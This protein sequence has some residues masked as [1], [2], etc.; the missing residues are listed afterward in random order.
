MGKPGKG[1]VPRVHSLQTE[2]LLMI[3]AVMVNA[4]FGM[5]EGGQT[6]FCYVAHG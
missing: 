2:M 4:D 1:C 6:P 5:C 3:D